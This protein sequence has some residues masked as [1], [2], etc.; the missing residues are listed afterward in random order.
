MAVQPL[1]W[2]LRQLP[3]CASTEM[4]LARWLAAREQRGRPLPQPG[5]DLALAVLARRQRW[6]VGQRGRPW[7]A[8]PGGLW[9]SAAIPWP[10]DPLASAPLALCT[11]LALALQL[12]GLGLRPQ[13]KWPNDL[14]I[15]G[16]KL[17]GVLPRLRWRGAAVR[18]AQ[19]GIGLNGVNRPPAGAI[20]L[21][22]ALGAV[23]P[24]ARAHP[25]AQPRRLLPLVLEALAWASGQASQPHA[26][27]AAA[28]ARLWCPAGGWQHGSRSWRVAGLTASGGL[29]LERPGERLTLTRSLEP[30]ICP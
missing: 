6:G 23:H 1:S 3:V 30:G 17:A 12:E 18:W 15:D 25:A 20:A 29:R 13:L 28:E 14:L 16:R 7:Q 24:R 4:E 2:R 8:P 9:L 26:V 21:A 19:L 22:E 5:S 11:A 10:E 27:L